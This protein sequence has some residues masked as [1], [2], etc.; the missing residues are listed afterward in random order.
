MRESCRKYVLSKF[1]LRMLKELASE[2]MMVWSIAAIFSVMKALVV[3][4]SLAFNDKCIE[5][6]WL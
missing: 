5:L 2:S 1:N 4:K 3:N 6:K